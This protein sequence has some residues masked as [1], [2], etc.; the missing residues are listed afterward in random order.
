MTKRQLVKWLEAKQS[1]AKAEVEIQ[2]ATAEKA[3][4]TQRDEAL[5]INETV[6][7]V[8]R[9]ISEADTVVSRWKEALEK[10]KG[11][12]TTCGWYTSLTTKLSDLSDKE[13]IRMYIM[14]DFTDGTDTLRQLRAKRSETL[15]EIE[16][17]YTNVIANV[18]S[19]KN[20]KTAVEYLEKLG[21][22]L[23][24]L[25]EAEITLLLPP[26]PLRWIQSFCLS[27]VKRN[28]NQ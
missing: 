20:A 26:S 9:L 18:E 22:D 17:N 15:R 7:E 11:I 1:D 4:F 21:F 10:V 27:E 8:F 25:I 5:K 13:N 6:D 23:S 12:D 3:Y 28:D 24:A 19:M 16:K 2:Y 14:K